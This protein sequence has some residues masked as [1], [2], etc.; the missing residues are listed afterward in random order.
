ML[1]HILM[2]GIVTVGY[3]TENRYLVDEKLRLNPKE[4][5]VH[6]VEENN[7]QI[8]SDVFNLLNLVSI[9]MMKKK[10]KTVMINNNTNINKT[11]NHLKSRSWLGTGAKI[12]QG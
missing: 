5:Q 2:H 8:P 1:Q 6:P 11:N 9:W 7:M 10:I 12:W 3:Y 4:I